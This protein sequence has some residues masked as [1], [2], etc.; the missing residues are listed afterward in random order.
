MTPFLPSLTVATVFLFRVLSASVP[1]MHDGS[2][3]GEGGGAACSGGNRKRKV[4]SKNGQR[5]KKDRCQAIAP[6][7]LSLVFLSS[8]AFY[9]V[10]CCFVCRPVLLSLLIIRSVADTKKGTV[11]VFFPS[12][13]THANN[14]CLQIFR[15]VYYS[16][17]APLDG[18]KVPVLW[19]WLGE[20]GRADNQQWAP[21]P[22]QAKDCVCLFAFFVLHILFNFH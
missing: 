15:P 12:F 17:A 10:P 18:L 11:A 7:F 16:F 1:S 14:F 2:L 13:F 6:R 21:P 9:C 3:E 20:E 5:S 19:C 22:K 8:A 4:Y